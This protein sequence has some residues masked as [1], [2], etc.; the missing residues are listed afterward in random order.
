MSDENTEQYWYNRGQVEA[1]ERI[2][3]LERQLAEARARIERLEE[4]LL[5]VGRIASGEDQVAADDTQGMIVVQKVVDAAL[6]AAPEPRRE[7]MQDLWDD[8]A[9]AEPEMI[10][11]RLRYVSVQIDRKT[12]DK[13]Q[14]IAALE[15]EA[16]HG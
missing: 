9:G 14:A 8:I 16:P 2:A 15:K 10:D 11:D 4:T 6:S 13:V 12:W 1:A 3:D 5:D 7:V